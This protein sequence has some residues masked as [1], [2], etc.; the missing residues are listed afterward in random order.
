MTDCGYWLG[1]PGHLL[2]VDGG[3]GR[4]ARTWASPVTIHDG[5]AAPRYAL[6]ATRRQ[7]RSWDITL[8][9]SLVTEI[10][11]LH[12]L[13]TGLTG[14][15]MLVDP[16]AQVTNVLPVE[17]STVSASGLPRVGGYDLADG[18]HVATAAHNPDATSNPMDARVWAG[19]GPVLPGR[20]VTAG[21][22][23]GSAF[24]AYVQLMFVDANNGPISWVDGGTVTGVDRLRRSTV[25]GTAPVNAVAAYVL[26]IRAQYLA[27][28]SLTWTDAPTE[29]GIGGL[30]QQ[31]VIE[32]VGD[33][34][35]YAVP[36]P[37]ASM[38]RLSTSFRVSEVGV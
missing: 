20:K 11:A 8:E 26:G 18:G 3:H 37:R 4:L 10:G 21:L 35:H 22:Y 29:W 7:P 24:D 27:Q 33:D 5:G 2:R 9:N 1:H 23:L 12:E 25:T 31:C 16:W 6:A 32:E 36:G 14:P 17:A 38:R 15:F 34:I 19:A 13:A 28:A 30:A